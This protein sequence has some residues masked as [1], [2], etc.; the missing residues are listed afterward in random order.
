[1]EIVVEGIKYNPCVLM[2]CC[3]DRHR[4]IKKQL[5]TFVYSKVFTCSEYCMETCGLSCSSAFQFWTFV[6]GYNYKYGKFYFIR[7]TFIFNYA[8]S[9]L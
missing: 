6:L 2:L 5:K 7:A 1:M 3:V 9:P 4:S 8:K